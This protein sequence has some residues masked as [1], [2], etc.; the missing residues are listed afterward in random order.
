M[1]RFFGARA[2]VSRRSCDV[3]CDKVFSDPE[4]FSD[5]PFLAILLSFSL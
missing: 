2:T 3:I 4:V 1:R 5:R